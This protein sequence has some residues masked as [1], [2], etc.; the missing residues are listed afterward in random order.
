[1]NNRI[2]LTLALSLILGFTFAQTK[3]ALFLGNSY[4]ASNNL[5][6]LIND[7]AN[8]AG[9][10]LIFDSNTP[11]GYTLQGHSTNTTSIN[12]INQGNWDFVVLQE[13]SQRPSFPISQVQSDVF[14]YAET[15]ADIIQNSN[16]CGNAM[17]FMTWGRE[18]GDQYNCANWP[19]VCT[20]EGMDSLLRLR[21]M[22]MADTNN[23]Y[24][25]PVGAVWNYI[26]HNY[27]N[28]DLYSGDGSHPSSAGSYAAACTFYSVI[29]RKDPMQITY[30]N[31]LDADVAL[32]IRTAA[33]AVAYDSLSQW[34]IG[35]YDKTADFSFSL[36]S[37]TTYQFTNLSQNA[38]AYLWDFGFSTDTAANPSFTFTTNGNHIVTL[39]AYDDCDTVK[40][41]DTVNVVSANLKSIKS[42]NKVIVSP[43]PSNGIFNVKSTK[44]TIKRITVYNVV[45]E[46]VYDKEF[47]SEGLSLENC[48]SG[49]YFVNVY[50]ENTEIISIKLII[51]K[52][53]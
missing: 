13:Q 25:S 51:N 40:F 31:S 27:P 41:S 39:Y 35:E 48:E 21:Y 5:P 30:K 52:T 18:N 4:T 43:N 44:H 11:G 32:H 46:K 47:K 9:D 34:H 23:A 28:I 37:G 14:P 10:T 3:R 7:C 16:P 45:G 26:R 2:L 8:S 20:Y 12:K 15:L 50:L 42:D 36:D 1:M 38:D 22:I 19:P 53:I 6:S 33:K 49:L 17:F 29:F 24:V